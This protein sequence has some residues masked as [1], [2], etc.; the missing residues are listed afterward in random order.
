M[1]ICACVC[2][3]AR[4]CFTRRKENE[5]GRLAKFWPLL[6]PLLICGPYVRGEGGG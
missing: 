3:R 4:V 1:P 6:R 2:V 5:E